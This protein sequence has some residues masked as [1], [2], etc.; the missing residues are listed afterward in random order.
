MSGKIVQI[1]C[2][3]EEFID[4]WAQHIPERYG[5]AVRHFGLLSPRAVSQTAAIFAVIGQ[6]QRPRPQRLRWAELLK[7]DFAWDP[8]L[9]QTGHRMQWVRRLAP[10]AAKLANQS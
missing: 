6:D 3:L 7:R 4:R 9:D 8:L 2:S 10:R 5:H 1:R